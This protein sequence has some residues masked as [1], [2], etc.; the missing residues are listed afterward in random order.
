MEEDKDD[1]VVRHS[2]LCA[3][4]AICI[5]NCVL[6]SAGTKTE[7]ATSLRLTTKTGICT[8]DDSH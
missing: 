8:R 6:I 7:D 1:L 3:S 2:S 5:E 4:S